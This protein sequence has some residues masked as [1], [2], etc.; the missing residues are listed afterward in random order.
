MLSIACINFL[1]SETT[2][3]RLIQSYGQTAQPTQIKTKILSTLARLNAR[4]AAKMQ[5][6]LTKARYT[7]SISLSPSQVPMPLS[8]ASVP[9]DAEVS[10]YE[11]VDYASTMASI[12]RALKKLEAA[13]DQTLGQLESERT[14]DL[15][16]L[17]SEIAHQAKLFRAKVRVCSSFLDRPLSREH[18]IGSATRELGNPT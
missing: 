15:K 13:R 9:Q 16:R 14:A 11:Q 10:K 18:R 6:K 1:C 17:N 7:K 4:L 8:K 3:P 12:Q 5:A 2:R